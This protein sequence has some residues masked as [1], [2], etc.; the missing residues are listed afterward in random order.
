MTGGSLRGLGGRARPGP[1]RL[2]A[3][4]LVDAR[5]PDGADYPLV[6]EARAEGLDL[7]AWARENRARLDGALDR[8]GGVLLRGFRVE[9]PAGF[10][11]F[12]RASAGEPLP[13]LERSSP[14]EPIEG[15]VYTSTSH[16][17][18]QA[19]FL[20]NEQSYNLTFPGRILFHCVTPAASGGATPVA[21][22]RRVLG[23]L[24]RALVD[25]FVARGYLYV[26]NFGG[27]LGLSWQEAFQTADRAE[28]EAYCRANQ[29]EARWLGGDRLR[30]SQRRPAVARRPRT[31]E[32][33]W[34]NHA[35]FFH[36]T[37]LG[38]EL[39]GRLRS[40]YAE[41]EMPNNTFYGDGSPIEPEA[42][43]AL[44]AAYLRA[45]VSVP[46]RQ[47]DCLLLDNVAMA[48]GR[49]PFAGERAVA[50]AMAEPRSWAALGH[51][52]AAGGGA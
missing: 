46:W 50:V 15:N 8:H 44:R 22:V 45:A 21:C 17:A 19:I 16:P 25:R 35:T 23:E 27:G 13:Y 10:A 37:T 18:E 26:R 33:A 47:G 34:F 1:T 31:G 39:A 42:L 36:V 38:P 14:R 9:G 6:I 4:G 20:H 5:A 24:P 30:T 32:L 11:A 12:A 49:E 51:G 29:I 28:V 41:D 7:G 3:E 43:E 2:S 52:V 48:H 40:L